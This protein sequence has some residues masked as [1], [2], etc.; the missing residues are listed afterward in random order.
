MTPKQLLYCI[1]GQELRTVDWLLLTLAMFFRVPLQEQHKSVCRGLSS[2]LLSCTFSLS[3]I[4]S[5]A[6]GL[7]TNNSESTQYKYVKE[8]QWLRSGET[9]QNKQPDLSLH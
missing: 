8:V 4:P 6:E 2:L 5:R 9:G 3:F 7:K 1:Y